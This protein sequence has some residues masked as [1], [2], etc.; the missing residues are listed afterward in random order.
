MIFDPFMYVWSISSLSWSSEAIQNTG[1]TGRSK[2]AEAL[3][4]NR[5]TFR[6]LNGTYNGPVNKQS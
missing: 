2:R 3:R 1:T 5:I 4:A 6:I